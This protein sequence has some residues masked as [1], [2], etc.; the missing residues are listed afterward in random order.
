MKPNLKQ[1]IKPQTS[2]LSSIDD[3]MSC[4]KLKKKK[5]S[6]LIVGGSNRFKNSIY[7]S[8]QNYKK[9]KTAINDADNIYGVKSMYLL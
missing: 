6:S 9:K 3:D 2:E 5:L 4:R 7:R 8:P 1:I